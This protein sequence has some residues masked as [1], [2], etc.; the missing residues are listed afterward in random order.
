M[1][2]V[3]EMTLRLSSREMSGI[4]CCSR[5]VLLKHVFLLNNIKNPVSTPQ[6]TRYVDKNK[7]LMLFRK[8]ISVSLWA[9]CKVFNVTSS[10]T[11]RNYCALKGKKYGRGRLD[12]D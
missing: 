11:Y 4:M 1:D 3:C 9:K 10:G 8:I 5:G 2:S 6:E 7:F 12:A